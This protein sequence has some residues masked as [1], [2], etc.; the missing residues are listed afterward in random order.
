[1]EFRI[2]I[3]RT[4]EGPPLAG[5]PV[6]LVEP[7]L[8]AVVAAGLV[9]DQQLG[10]LRLKGLLWR[11]GPEAEA[12]LD[13]A[14]AYG[15]EP[16]LVPHPRLAGERALLADLAVRLTPRSWQ[17]LAL[18]TEGQDRL[19]RR[20]DLHPGD[21]PTKLLF[22]RSAG[23]WGAVVVDPADWEDLLTDLIEDGRRRLAKS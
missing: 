9:Q 3:V 5:R 14:R 15:P 11:T 16:R 7:D 6:S 2:E 18:L 23:R 21:P 1:M 19:I 10:L 13:E 8:R 12:I 17:A 20:L 4:P 22:Q